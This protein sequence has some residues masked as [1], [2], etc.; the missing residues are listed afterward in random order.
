SQPASSKSKRSKKH[1]S[2]KS[3]SF[4]EASD[5]KS[6]STFLSLKDYDNYTP[7]TKRVFARNLQ[8]FSKV[9]Y[10]QIAKDN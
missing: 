5:S 9:L 3:K 2:K 4:P 6:S 8:G 7:T 1:K 10:A